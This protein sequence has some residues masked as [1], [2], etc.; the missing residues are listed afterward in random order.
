VKK[1]Q[2]YIMVK[3]PC[4]GRVKT[5][6]GRD[7]GMTAAAWWFRHQSSAVIRR[8]SNDP[9]WETI[10]AVAP[11]VDGLNSR[12]WPRHIPRWP[13][14]RGDLGDRMGRIFHHAPFGPVIIIGADIPNIT[15][16]LINTAFDALGNHNAV[17]GPAFDGGYWLIGLKRGATPVTKTLFQ[18]VRWSHPETMNDTLRSLNTDSVKLIDSLRDVDTVV[19]LIH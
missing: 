12:V 9:R 18:N 1:G 13:Q 10:L 3:Q 16:K 15:P 17:L 19:D 14:G 7:I 4:A 8:L 5:R 2:L 11:D 6:L